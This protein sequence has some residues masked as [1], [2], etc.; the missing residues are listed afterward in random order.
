MVDFEAIQSEVEAGYINVQQHPSADLRILNY[1]AKTQFEW[2]WTQETMICR[3]LILDGANN[4]VARPFPK[5]FSYEQLNGQVPN[6]SFEAFEKMDGSLGILYWV[7]DEPWIATR[8]SFVSDQAQRATRIFRERYA[9]LDFDRD[10]TYLFEIILPS[11]R[12]VVDY[13]QTEDLFLLAVI[14][15]ATGFEYPLF[16]SDVPFGVPVVK[17]YDAITDFAEILSTQDRNREGFVVRFESGVRVKIKEEYR[18]LHKLLTGIN[19]RHI[20]EMLKN[21]DDVS[22]LAERVPDEY[23][24]WLSKV[25]SGLIRRFTEIEGQAKSD[26]KLLEDRKSTALYYQTCPNPGILFSMLDGKDYSE[27]IWKMIRP[28]GGSAFRCDIDA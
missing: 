26:F 18:R 23:Y 22:A 8:G 3:G 16:D 17:R 9:S 19:P 4:I 25:K 2:K 13:G 5:F 12:I 24:A 7:G 21:G 6:E 28:V 27:Q 11:N 20:W 10:L 1:S 14:S 15:T